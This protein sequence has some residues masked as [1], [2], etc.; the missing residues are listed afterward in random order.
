MVEL[1]RHTTTAGNISNGTR[2]VQTS[3][4]DVIQG[5][6]SITDTETTGL[7]TTHGSRTN[8]GHTLELC[9]VKQFTCATLR[10]TLSDD[11]KATD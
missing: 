10:N 6:T 4:N 8:Q 9:T 11:S 1:V 5:A 3:S 7:D 2:T